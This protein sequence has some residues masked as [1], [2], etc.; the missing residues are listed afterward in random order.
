ML[1]VVV[2]STCCV[3]EGDYRL[4]QMRFGKWVCGG[5]TGEWVSP[6]PAVSG[7]KVVMAY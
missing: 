2:C 3:S 5:T 6:N 4:H 7:T 1:A